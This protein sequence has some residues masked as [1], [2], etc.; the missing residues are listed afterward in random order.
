M[1]LFLFKLARAFQRENFIKAVRLLKLSQML[2]EGNMDQDMQDKL[3]FH[4]HTVTLNKFPISTCDI[5][6]VLNGWYCGID[7]ALSDELVYSMNHTLRCVRYSKPSIGVFQPYLKGVDSIFWC[8]NFYQ[9]FN[10]LDKSIA[11]LTLS[12]SLY[13]SF[14]ISVAKN[15]QEAEIKMVWGIKPSATYPRS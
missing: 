14:L 5:N 3:Y 15:S 9:I 2:P 13:E 10:P 7:D 6:D 1:P 11:E 4:V 8:Y 12:R